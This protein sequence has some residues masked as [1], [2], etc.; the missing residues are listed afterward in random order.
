MSRWDP[1]GIFDNREGHVIARCPFSHGFLI[2]DQCLTA[3]QTPETWVE[4]QDILKS[5]LSNVWPWA[6]QIA[7]LCLSFPSAKE[8]G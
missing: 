6:N 8:M 4:V 7:S 1:G 2:G 5:Q 3:G